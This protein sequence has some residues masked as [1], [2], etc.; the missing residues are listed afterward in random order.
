MQSSIVFSPVFSSNQFHVFCVV[1]SFLFLWFPSFNFSTSCS[2]VSLPQ[3][4]SIF[5]IHFLSKSPHWCF[6]LA[7]SFIICLISHLKIHVCIWYPYHVCSS[8]FF[9]FAHNVLLICPP[10]TP[11][12]QYP[13]FSF[14]YFIVLADF[15]IFCIYFALQLFSVL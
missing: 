8:P 10:I 14:I 3:L 2:F 1:K 4:V 7:H 13:V 11:Q 6:I 12:L 5:S 15:F 9:S